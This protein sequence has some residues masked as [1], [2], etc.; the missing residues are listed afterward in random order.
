MWRALNL[1]LHFRSAAEAGRF[2]FTS[3]AETARARDKI[4]PA[5]FGAKTLADSKPLS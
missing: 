2:A 1:R 3:W 4:H 5:I